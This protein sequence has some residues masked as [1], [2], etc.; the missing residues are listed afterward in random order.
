MLEN[1]ALNKDLMQ[2]DGLHPNKEGQ[3]IVLQN[4]LPYLQPLLDKIQSKK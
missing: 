4:I 3:P 1:V 2:S